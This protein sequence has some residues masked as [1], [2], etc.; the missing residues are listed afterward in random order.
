[1]TEITFSNY[2]N[3]CR[4]YLE[5]SINY[6]TYNRIIKKIRNGAL[7]SIFI[8]KIPAETYFKTNLES[9]RVLLND[10][11]DGIYLSFQRPYDNLVQE[12]NKKNI[13]IN[14]LWIIDYI[15][16]INNDMIENKTRCIQIPKNSDIKYI[17]KL[18]NNCIPKLE[19][20]KKFVFIDSLSTMALHENSYNSLFFPEILINKTRENSSD[21]ILFIF[22]IAEELS[23]KKYMKNI[24]KYADEH[25]HL[26]LC[27]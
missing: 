19:S 16:P 23:R 18:V 7:N 25:I 17:I 2:R 1:M 21:D 11:F 8:F 22:N 4:S 12:F 5:K 27:T 14:K 20:E 10:N 15:S 26:G 6:N 3:I 13:D 9:L 24:N